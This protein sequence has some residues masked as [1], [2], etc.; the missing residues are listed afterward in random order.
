MTRVEGVWEGGIWKSKQTHLPAPAPTDLF[1][2]KGVT[3]TVFSPEQ[4][5]QVMF[6]V[7]WRCPEFLLSKLQRLRPLA[8]AGHR[9]IRICFQCLH[10]YWLGAKFWPWSYPWYSLWDTSLP[11][12]F[13]LLDLHWVLFLLE[14]MLSLNLLET[15]GFSF[16][17]IVAMANTVIMQACPHIPTCEPPASYWGT[18]RISEKLIH[19]CSGLDLS[20]LAAHETGAVVHQE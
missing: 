2:S 10:I 13:L 20:V 11:L 16:I 8:L 19:S 3:G 5:V 9:G 17:P 14:K 15:Q 6:W 12:G 4:K 18:P 1:S 7:V